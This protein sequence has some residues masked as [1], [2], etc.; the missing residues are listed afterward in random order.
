MTRHMISSNRKKQILEAAV[1]CFG[2]NGYH[3]TAVDDIASAAGLSKGSVYWHFK[4]KR[5]LFL[6]TLELWGEQVL[7]TAQRGVEQARNP[8][9][10]LRAIFR[11]MGRCAATNPELIRTWRQMQVAVAPDPRFENRVQ[12][13]AEALYRLVHKVLAEGIEVGHF[14]RVP[15]K[16]LTWHVLAVLEGSLMQSETFKGHDL[17]PL[18]WNVLANSIIT[19]LESQAGHSSAG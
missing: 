14:R 3:E 17:E 5:D 4:N 9:E 10:E 16:P 13:S 6:S 1:K 18:S 15:L 11:S 8:G 2:S 19:F 7:D 12:A